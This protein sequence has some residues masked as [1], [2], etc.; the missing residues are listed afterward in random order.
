M[1]EQEE[2]DSSKNTNSGYFGIKKKVIFF[3]FLIVTW[4]KINVNWN[5]NKM[6]PFLYFSHLPSFI[7]KTKDKNSKITNTLQKI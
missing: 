4:N 7:T 6:G 2:N 3:F 1:G 5:K